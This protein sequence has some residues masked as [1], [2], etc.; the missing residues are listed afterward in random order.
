M[1]RRR[2]LLLDAFGT[3]I[4][5]DRPGE[6]LRA[7]LSERL[8]VE[9]EPERARAAMQAEMAH[10]QAN[11]RRAAD[12]TSLA[13][14]R[15]ECAAIVMD[16]SGVDA[17]KETALAVLSDAVV[18]RAY[19][20]SAPALDMARRLGIAT[21]VVSNGDCSMPSLLDQAALQVDVVV[22]SATAGAAK[23]DPAIFRL[24]LRRLDVAAAEALH[25]GD[26]DQADG[27]GARAAG[28]DVVIIDRSGSSGPGRIAS[29]AEL[30]PM[31]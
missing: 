19:D 27:E 21:A 7:S 13:S 15:R 9:V 3:L 14:L 29:L 25:V 11:C 20:D 28:I 24:A 8:G 10:Y 22:D 16:M 12:A 6:R 4:T 17:P 1:S 31:L 5:V 18:I 23:P 2:A 30:E 26:H